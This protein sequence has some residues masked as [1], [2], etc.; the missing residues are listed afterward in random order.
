[1]RWKCIN[2]HD[3]KSPIYELTDEYDSRRAL[4]KNFFMLLDSY[5]NHRKMLNW[6]DHYLGPVR[7]G[8]VRA[9]NYSGVN[10]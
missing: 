3:Y 5:Q 6:R 1:M 8:A 9:S 2:I 7:R 4:P 10:P